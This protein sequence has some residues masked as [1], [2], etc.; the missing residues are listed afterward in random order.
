MATLQLQAPV[1]ISLLDGIYYAVQANIKIYQTPSNRKKSLKTVK[2][3]DEK[4]CMIN[5]YQEMEVFLETVLLFSEQNKHTNI[6]KMLNNFSSQN[7]SF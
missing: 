4:L 5:R 1:V 3:E 6:N 7:K 2:R